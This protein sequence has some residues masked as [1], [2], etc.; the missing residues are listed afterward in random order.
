MAHGAGRDARREV[1][2]R[3]R[4]ESGRGSLSRG[5]RRSRGIL[6]TGLGQRER[7]DAVGRRLRATWPEGIKH[8][9]SASERTGGAA[10]GPIFGEVTMF[11]Q[12]T[13]IEAVPCSMCA[14]PGA[15]GKW[16]LCPGCRTRLVDRQANLL[17]RLAPTH[18]LGCQRVMHGP[19]AAGGVL[20][21]GA[22]GNIK[23]T[24]GRFASRNAA[25]TRRRSKPPRTK[26]IVP[27]QGRLDT[28]P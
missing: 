1:G 13:Q 18:C 2:G 27:V 22:G 14:G 16:A 17:D 26:A 4:T 10:A 5:A 7:R 6:A 25:R 24:G 28:H 23:G 9:P 3:D 8:R 11:D 19:P 20:C 12:E 21:P 15:T